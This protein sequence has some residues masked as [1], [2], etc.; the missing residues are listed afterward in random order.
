[1]KSLNLKIVF[2]LVVVT[3]AGCKDDTTQSP[4]K[5]I[6]EKLAFN[7]M[8]LD[9]RVTE[10]SIQVGWL[11]YHLDS[12]LTELE[13]QHGLE[14]VPFDWA[15]AR[16]FPKVKS[17]PNMAQKHPSPQPFWVP[18]KVLPTREI[19]V[20]KYTDSERLAAVIGMKCRAIT[21]NMLGMDKY[22]KHLEER[23]KRLE[24]HSNK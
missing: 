19:E 21:A 2:V 17:D 15:E 20:E 4:P 18:Y 22:I 1:M 8:E 11:R 24:E 7:V 10:L 14:P 23:L 12:C 6:S 16:G 3:L 13:A 5:Q 9:S